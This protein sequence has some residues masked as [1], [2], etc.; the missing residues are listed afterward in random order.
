MHEG[1]PTGHNQLKSTGAP[2]PSF[3]EGLSFDDVLLIPKRTAVLPSEVDIST[4]FLPGMLLRVPIVSA[5][6]DTV[7]D[8]RLAREALA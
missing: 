6:M 1:S 5:P 8:A 2:M 4:P 7:T 3:R